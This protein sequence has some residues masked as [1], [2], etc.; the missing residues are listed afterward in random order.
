M[1]MVLLVGLF[2]CFDKIRK[3]VRQKRLT[4][5]TSVRIIRKRYEY[6]CSIAR[7][8]EDVMTIIVT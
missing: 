1:E 7:Y 4:N 3:N 2:C 6:T 5:S 8:K